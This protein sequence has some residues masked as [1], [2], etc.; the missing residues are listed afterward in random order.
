[1]FFYEQDLCL[2]SIRGPEAAHCLFG[3]AGIPSRLV[4]YV[5]RKLLVSVLPIS[6]NSENRLADVDLCDT[7]VF[8]G[9]GSK[10]LFR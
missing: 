3:D 9:Y 10:Q 5:Y 2:L 4:G 7:P 8:M 1:M 6:E